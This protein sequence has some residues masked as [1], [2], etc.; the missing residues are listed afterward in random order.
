MPIDSPASTQRRL[1]GVGILC[2]LVL[3]VGAQFFWSRAVVVTVSKL[4]ELS[5]TNAVQKNGRFFAS[6]GVVPFSGILVDYYPSGA[7][8]SRTSIQEGRI[9]GLSRGFYE[10]GQ[11]QIEERFRAGVSHGLRTKWRADG[12]KLSA[13]KIVNGVFDG[14][15]VKWHPNGTI[16]QEISMKEGQAHGVSKSWDE[17]GGLL[18]EVSMTQGVP[19]TLPPGP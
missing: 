5:L 19:D 8:R 10:N 4:V 1:L 11:L 3:L 7:L 12:S 9:D 6:D 18:S 14:K 17:E 13:G 16:S 15:F 2:L